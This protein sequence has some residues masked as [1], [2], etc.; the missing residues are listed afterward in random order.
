MEMCSIDW[1]KFPWQA[2][3]TL[4][5]AIIASTIAFLGARLIAKEQIKISSRQADIADGQR[6]IAAQNAQIALMSHRE[7]LFDRRYLIHSRIRSYVF[8]LMKNRGADDPELPTKKLQWALNRSKFL[9]R[10][11]VRIAIDGALELAEELNDLYREQITALNKDILIKQ[12]TATRAKIRKSLNEVSALMAPEMILFD[13]T[14]ETLERS[15][16]PQ[17]E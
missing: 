10:P 12:R 17:S 15:I 2:V 14:D 1:S 16:A 9:F 8:R 6:E 4:L 3:A 13:Q 7:K 5:S 11:E